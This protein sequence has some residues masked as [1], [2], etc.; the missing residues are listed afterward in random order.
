M[1][2]IK[3]SEMKTIIELQRF[4]LTH[5]E[6]LSIEESDRG[7]LLR[8]LIEAENNED[9]YIS[10]IEQYVENYHSYDSFEKFLRPNKFVW[11]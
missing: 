10:L 5:G 7:E 9:S 4:G 11:D 8:A 1:I 2:E 3:D 6:I